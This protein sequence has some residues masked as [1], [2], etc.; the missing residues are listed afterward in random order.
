MVRRIKLAKLKFGTLEFYKAWQERVNK[1]EEIAK[2]GLTS[3]L[4]YVFSDKKTDVGTPLTFIITWENGKITEVREG[5]PDEPVE[6][7][8]TGD[9]KTWVGIISGTIDATRAMVTGKYK[10]EG[11]MSK[12][13]KLMKPFQAAINIQKE[14]LLKECEY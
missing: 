1:N 14:I 5:T 3:K 2:T 9:Y 11:P 8:F 7:K 13:L 12:M 4:A 6:F 10:M